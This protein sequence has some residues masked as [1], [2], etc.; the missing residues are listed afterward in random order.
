MCYL[1]L[2]MQVSPIVKGNNN[3]TM[4]VCVCVCVCVCIVCV[5]SAT[6]SEMLRTMPSTELSV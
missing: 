1:T 6:I 5:N 4:Y 2:H 3:S